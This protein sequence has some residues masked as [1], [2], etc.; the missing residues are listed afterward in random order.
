[1]AERATFYYHFR[2]KYDLIAWIFVHE[3]DDTDIL[4][5]DSATKSME[6]MRSDYLFYKRAYEDTSQTPQSRYLI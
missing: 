6:K 2:D 3:A 5:A 4:D 1:M